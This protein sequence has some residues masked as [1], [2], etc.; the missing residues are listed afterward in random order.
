MVL[1]SYSTT[2][3]QEHHLYLHACPCAAHQPCGTLELCLVRLFT[4]VMSLGDLCNTHL[5]LLPPSLCC[6]GEGEVYPR[7]RQHPQNP[8]PGSSCVEFG[9]MLAG[10]KEEAQVPPAVEGD[11]RSESAWGRVV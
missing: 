11:Q 8:C 5:T 4:C 2:T 9:I 10:W 6:L 1:G 3:C 7:Q